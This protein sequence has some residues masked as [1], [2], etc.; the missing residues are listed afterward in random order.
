MSKL[1]S[2]FEI[3]I[4]SQAEEKSTTKDESLCEPNNQ[5]ESDASTGGIDITEIKIESISSDEETVENGEQVSSSYPNSNETE[6]E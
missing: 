6:A 2:F 1:W 5:T 4:G 3:Q